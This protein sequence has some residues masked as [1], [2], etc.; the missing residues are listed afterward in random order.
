MVTWHGETFTLDEL[1]VIARFVRQIHLWTPESLY[2]IFGGPID[3]DRQEFYG[4]S[5]G[6]L[7]KEAASKP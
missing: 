4:L 1:Q 6:E 5:L 3:P 7:I 2:M